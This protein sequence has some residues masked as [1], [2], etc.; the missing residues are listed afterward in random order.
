MPPYSKFRDATYQLSLCL[1]SNSLVNQM[2]A[3]LT[4][5]V[6]QQEL[7]HM[8]EYLCNQRPLWQRRAPLFATLPR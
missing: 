8:F 4:L 1:A 5:K 6:M 3:F 7:D 2:G